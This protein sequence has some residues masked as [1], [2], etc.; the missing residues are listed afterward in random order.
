LGY[1]SIK[2]TKRQRGAW[3]LWRWGWS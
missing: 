2:P 1:I 3:C